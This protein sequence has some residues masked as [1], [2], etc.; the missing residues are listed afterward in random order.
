MILKEKTFVDFFSL[1]IC[2]SFTVWWIEP[3]QY[4]CFCFYFVS[5]ISLDS[6]FAEF[7]EIFSWIFQCDLWIQRTKNVIRKTTEKYADTTSKYKK[8]SLKEM[9]NFYTNHVI[10]SKTVIEEK[11][12]DFFLNGKCEMK[13]HGKL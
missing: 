3:N 9:S 12:K 8:K 7:E 10:Y 2:H 11:E 4:R 6:I 13:R 1:Y 5:S